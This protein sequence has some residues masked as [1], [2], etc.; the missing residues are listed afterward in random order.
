[1]PSLPVNLLLIL[2]AKNSVNKQ[3]ILIPYFEKLVKSE[4]V[5]DILFLRIINNYDQI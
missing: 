3:V 4:I 1:M 5:V 2:L